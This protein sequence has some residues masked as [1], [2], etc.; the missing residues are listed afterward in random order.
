MCEPVCD[1]FVAFAASIL[2]IFGVENIE[3]FGAKLADRARAA[4]RIPTSRIWRP[5][6]CFFRRVCLWQTRRVCL[7]N[8]NKQETQKRAVCFGPACKV[9]QTLPSR[10]GSDALAA[11]QATQLAKQLATQPSM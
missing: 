3:I 1:R 8:T 2:Q 4:L 7:A 5:H 10:I 6:L 9:V 11:V